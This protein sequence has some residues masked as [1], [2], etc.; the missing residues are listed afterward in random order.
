M[1][2]I[3][4]HIESKLVCLTQGEAG[5]HAA[6]SEP[7]GEGVRVV[8]PAVIATLNHGRAAKLTAPDH[9]GILQQAALL[10]IQHQR[11]ARLVRQTALGLQ[12]T[13]ESAVVIPCLMEEL[14]KADTALDKAAG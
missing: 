6:T 14:H 8:I 13:R 2:F 12:S 11:S 5:F 7:H 4:R 10:Q 9:N 3:L 1:H